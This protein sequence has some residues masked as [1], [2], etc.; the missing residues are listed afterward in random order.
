MKKILILFSL[1]IVATGVIISQTNSFA[2]DKAEKQDTSIV[3]TDSVSSQMVVEEA[4]VVDSGDAPKSNV[5][6]G[7]EKKSGFSLLTIIRGLFGM[8]V[9][10]MIAWAFS[11]NK[12]HVDWKVIIKGLAIQLI[13]AI[14]ILYVPFVAYAFE[15]VGKIFVKILDFTK[16]EANFYL[17]H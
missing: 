5:L 8:F 3:Q 16:L 15:F 10:I 17:A 9:L 14:C 2:H 13:L 1:V 7:G 4:P 6:L 11:A 12:K